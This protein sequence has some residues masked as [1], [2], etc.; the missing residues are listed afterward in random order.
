MCVFLRAAGFG[1][2]VNSLISNIGRINTYSVKICIVGA[3]AF[4]GPNP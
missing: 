1:V 2:T 3:D 4:I